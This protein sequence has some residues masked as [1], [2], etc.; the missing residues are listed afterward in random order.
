MSKVIFIVIFLFFQID[1]SFCQDKARV[2]FKGTTG[3]Q[4]K[5]SQLSDTSL[6]LVTNIDLLRKGI[7]VTL[8][9][10]G[11][12][13]SNV[14]VQTVSLGSTLTFIKSRLRIGSTV[15]ID[16]FVTKNPKTGKDIYIEGYSYKIIA[17]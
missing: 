13:F 8:Y 6:K 15:S 9:L 17:D 4:I 7:G 3:D 10:S 5:I 2:Y 14:M 16:G 11:E 1:E 12:G